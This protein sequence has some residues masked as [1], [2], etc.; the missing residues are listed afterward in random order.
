MA[1]DNVSAYVVPTV[2]L[3][4]VSAYSGEEIGT[5]DPG[6]MMKLPE[7]P[8]IKAR[9]LPVSTCPEELAMHIQGVTAYS[10]VDQITTPD[11]AYLV[12]AASPVNSKGVLP[13]ILMGVNVAGSEADI[14]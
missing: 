14:V 1:P 12:L 9:Y 2:A 13:E 5:T 10:V 7:P 3:T 11:S 8:E 6:A 4:L